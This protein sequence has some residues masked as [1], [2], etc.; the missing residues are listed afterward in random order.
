M[1]S[2]YLG[3]LCIQACSVILALVVED[4]TTSHGGHSDDSLLSPSASGKNLLLSHSY[5]QLFQQDRSG[6]GQWAGVTV[7]FL[8][9]PFFF[10]FALTQ[11]PLCTHRRGRQNRAKPLVTFSQLTRLQE[12]FFPSVDTERSE[13][14]ENL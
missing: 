9:L 14:R 7:S 10:F 11:Q 12:I 13:K 2:G 3:C 4:G 1:T 8:V 6:G 5:S